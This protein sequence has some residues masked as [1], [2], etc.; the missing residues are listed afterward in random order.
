MISPQFWPPRP[1]SD[2]AGITGHRDNTLDS[3]PA[4]RWAPTSIHDDRWEEA[5]DLGGSAEEFAEVG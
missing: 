1:Q 5:S 3:F 4:L 2:P